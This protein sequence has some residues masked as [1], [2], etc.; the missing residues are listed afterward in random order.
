MKKKGGRKGRIVGGR[1]K[2]KEVRERNKHK[3]NT[4][5]HLKVCL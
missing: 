2:M 5:Q 1:F 3:E 4:G